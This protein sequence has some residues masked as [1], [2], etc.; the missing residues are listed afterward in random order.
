MTAAHEAISGTEPTPH[1]FWKL[2][3]GSVGVVYGD[4]GTSPLYALREA[5]RSAA[6]DGLAESEVV[7]IVSILLW[8]L[9]LIVSFKYV[10]LILRA[11]NRGEGGT[12]SLL[13]LAQRA[14]GRRTTPLLVLGVLGTALFYGDA[15]I[16]PAISVLSAVEG[17]ELVQ[18]AFEP[19]V[20]PITVT[21]L[22]LLFWVQSVGTD[23]VAIF[24]G[25]I[26]LVWFLVLAALGLRH[27]GDNLGI[28]GAFNPAMAVEFLASHGTGALPA[29]GSVFLAVTGAEALYA[30]MGH[31]G[32][33]PIRVAWAGL[34][35]P[36]LALNY[37]GQGALVLARPE[38]LANPFFLMT[39]AWALLPLVL[40]ATAAT[41]IA[42]QAVITGAY[43]ITHQAV[44][45]GLLPRLE[46]RH[47]SEALVGQI[48]MPRVNWTLLAGVLVLVVFF[49]NSG[50]LASAYGIA[51]TGTM[52]I[53]S[54]LAIVV[55]RK[56]WNWPIAAVVAVIVPILVIEAIFLG[57]NL[58][59]VLDGGYVPLIMAGVV[60]VLV[61]TW[62]RG[63]AIVQRKAHTDAVSLTS[64]MSM[65]KKPSI[66]RVPGTAV[67]LTSDPDIA[68]SALMHNLKHN[69]VLH[70]RN[71][72]VTVTVATTPTVTDADR[73]VVEQLDDNF[74][75][76]NLVFGYMEQ[77]NVPR[78]LALAKKH[79]IKFEVM[80]TSFF[81]NRRSFKPSTESGMPLWQDRLFIAMTKT[82][83]D[84]T[85][86]YRLPSNRVLELGQQF[87]I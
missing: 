63:T 59:K 49:G 65:M 17:L 61:W 26:T 27:I 36:A 62:V 29:M 21:I 55:L 74:T 22:I 34:V 56:V 1:K 44:Q 66:V 68:P 32:R 20:L 18:P 85:G 52:V 51:V 69:S 35:F 33:G 46:T 23:R 19:Y 53:T 43:S 72:I 71:L 79:G 2:V 4:I 82:A 41:V 40:L 38:A 11:D 77:P 6:R 87:V 16:T 78:A 31:F 13:A 45:L 58:I 67:F 70:Q 80:S 75:R 83:T 15:V 30:D 50:A 57:A 81:L 54:I 5:L 86:F 47:T 64:L 60:G 39:P 9:I 37:L 25:P 84:A 14:L 76:V 10:M 42:S 8:T 48:Y 12:L 3:L 24:F 7:G 28:F 73:S